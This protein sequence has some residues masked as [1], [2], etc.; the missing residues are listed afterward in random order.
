M[1]VPDS[2][3]RT[4]LSEYEQRRTVAQQQAQ[5]RKTALYRRIPRLQ[6]IEEEL[7]AIG[8]RAV[9]R[10]LQSSSMSKEQIMTSLKQDNER[11]LAEKRRLLSEAGVSEEDLAVHYQCPI[12]QDTGYV[13][14]QK[15]RCLQQRLIDYAYDQSNL[16]K[17]IRTENFS[18][19]DLQRFS[20]AIPYGESH[21]PRDNAAQVRELTQA[22]AR[23]FP[24]NSPRNLFF[25][26]VSGTGKTFFCNCIAKAVLDAGYTALYLTA[27]DF[28][29]AM[30]AYRFRDKS[31]A[32]P[33]PSIHDLIRDIDLLI[34]DDLG[35]EFN[36]AL[37]VSDLFYGVNQRLLQQKSTIIS[38]NLSLEQIEKVYTERMASRIAGNYRLIKLFGP[39]LRL[40]PRLA[41]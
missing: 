39:D 19:F 20:T 33:S 17:I 15:C 38:T 26:G 7:E 16:K 22:Y 36:T 4:L 3:I 37:S 40:S 12:C 11:L 21:S 18:T 14:G 25:Y 28:C 8:L 34:I 31:A 1:P 6:A 10:Y 24:E 27:Y 23:Q 29:S 32:A 41:P 5:D 2:L 30:E 9:R 13:G 35:T